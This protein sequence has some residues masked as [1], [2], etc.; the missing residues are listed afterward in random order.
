M[1]QHMTPDMIERYR[2]SNELEQLAVAVYV[3]RGDDR[4]MRAYKSES[5]TLDWF[6]TALHPPEQDAATTEAD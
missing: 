3:G 1:P 4:L 2:R 5:E 6:W